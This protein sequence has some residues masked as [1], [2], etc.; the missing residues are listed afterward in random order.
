MRALVRWGFIVVVLLHGLIHL[1]GV[2]RGFG[3]VDV[4]DRHRDVGPLLGTGWLLGTVCVVAAGVLVIRRNPQWWAV[5]AGAAVVSQALIVTSWS[6]AAVGT[7]ANVVM[8]A[9]AGYGYASEGSRGLRAE[10]RRQV[11]S[12]LD[13]V[14]VSAA[15]TEDDLARLPAPVA[16][17]LHRCGAV[18]NSRIAGFRAHVHGRIR[19]GAGKPWMPFTAE[20][21][22]TCGPN[23][24]RLFLIDATM[25]G[26]PIDVLH[27]YRSRSARLRGRLA[28]IFPIMDVSGPALARAE[29]V[30]LFNDLCVLAPAALVDAPISWQ[31]VD[32]LHA[33]GTFTNG[34]YTVSAE[35]VFN[36]DH[37]LIDFVSDDR[38][39]VASDGKSFLQQRWSTPVTEYAEFGGRWVGARGECSW[40]APEP[41]GRFV[42]LEFQ[43]DD[44]R[45]N[46]GAPD[47]LH[48]SWARDAHHANGVG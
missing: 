24:D 28:S 4:A 18:G 14:A 16:G 19:A 37:E 33:R 27:T 10:F 12:A 15:V 1:V 23:P 45:Y 26:L 29:T 6:D 34:P 30:T 36:A 48:P 42:Y 22:N 46:V 21:V 2:V 31:P 41:E 35:L 20:Q 32:D 43:L 25:F 17:Y 38:L 39:R 9:G 47:D 7:V 13:D 8:L 44:I 3:W 11:R 40:H 5:T